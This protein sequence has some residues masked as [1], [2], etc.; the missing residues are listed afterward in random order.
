[1]LRQQLRAVQDRDAGRACGRD[2]RHLIFDRGGDDEARAWPELRAG[3][4]AVLRDDDHAGALELCAQ[5]GVLPQVEG[6]IAA[7]GAGAAQH[8]EQG[9]RAHAAAADAGEVQ[10]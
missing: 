2:I 7:A 4:R 3:E 6:A 9:Q 5:V 1:M 8:L 10:P